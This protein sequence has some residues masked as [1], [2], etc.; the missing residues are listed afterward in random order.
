M[1]PK[2]QA[3]FRVENRCP[4]RDSGT[5]CQEESV[6]EFHA[7]NGPPVPYIRLAPVREQC[8]LMKQKVKEG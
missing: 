7:G 6:P 3:R 5:D 2:K 8:R 1:I 4:P